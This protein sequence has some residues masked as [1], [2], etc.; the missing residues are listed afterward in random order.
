V[1]T[2]KKVHSPPVPAVKPAYAV[3]LPMM[4]RMSTA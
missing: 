1:E 2:V 4:A 3:S